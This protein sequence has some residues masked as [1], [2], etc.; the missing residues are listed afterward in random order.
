M[1]ARIEIAECRIH[2]GDWRVEYFLG[3]EH[4]G[5]GSCDVAIFCGPRAKANAIAYCEF[6]HQLT[7]LP[8]PETYSVAIFKKE[9]TQ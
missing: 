1:T 8:L 6:L 7:G 5:D 9:G 3:D 2:Q 4:G